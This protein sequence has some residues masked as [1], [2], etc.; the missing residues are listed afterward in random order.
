ML[1]RMADTSAPE[2]H[3]PRVGLCMHWPQLRLT[4]T[5]YLPWKRVQ[6][7]QETLLER[8]CPLE[9]ICTRVGHWR[10]QQVVHLQIA[11]Y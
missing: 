5:S 6:R 4:P 11:L 1:V 2:E 8:V 10:Q 9:S 3:G 7:V